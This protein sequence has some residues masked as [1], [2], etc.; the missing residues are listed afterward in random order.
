MEMYVFKIV[1]RWFYVEILRMTFLKP[2][3]SRNIYISGMNTAQPVGTCTL[4]NFAAV[5]TIYS[6]EQGAKPVKNNERW[7]PSCTFSL[8][9]MDFEETPILSYRH[10]FCPRARH[11]LFRSLEMENKERS[12]IIMALPLVLAY[13]NVGRLSTS[14]LCH[15]STKHCTK[16]YNLTKNLIGRKQACNLNSLLTLLLFSQQPFS[17]QSLDFT[18]ANCLPPPLLPS[19]SSLSGSPAATR[20]SVPD[21]LSKSSHT[22]RCCPKENSFY[23]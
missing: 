15:N 22:I 4:R 7:S 20:A 18:H 2:D 17:H 16:P 13:T 23:C 3:L 1:H 10:F 21:D 9:C 5:I 19:S 8:T 11:R 6:L 12:G 14:L